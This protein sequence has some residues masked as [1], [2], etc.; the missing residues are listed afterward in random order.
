M[1]KRLFPQGKYRLPPAPELFIWI[2]NKYNWKVLWYLCIC[3]V[4]RRLIFNF[5]KSAVRKKIY[6][7]FIPVV[8]FR[9]F[10]VMRIISWQNVFFS[11]QMT[12][13]FSRLPTISIILLTFL[14]YTVQPQLNGT[15]PCTRISGICYRFLMH[16]NLFHSCKA[17]YTQR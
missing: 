1:Q 17:N 6:T 11:M 3:S 9:E 12:E 8:F 4:C 14:I 15:L 10:Q 2:L 5:P 16:N 7:S 13:H